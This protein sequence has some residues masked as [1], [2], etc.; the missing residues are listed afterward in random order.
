MEYLADIDDS[1]ELGMLE[2]YSE[3]DDLTNELQERNMRPRE[4]CGTMKW[5]QR[6][7]KELKRYL[8]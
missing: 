5:L 3:V 8:D 2:Y 7:A 1:N 6:L 4:I